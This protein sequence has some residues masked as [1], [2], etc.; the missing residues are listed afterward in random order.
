MW[1]TG[2]RT[3][4]C[5]ELLQLCIFRLVMY[6]CK[7]SCLANIFPVVVLTETWLS[8]VETNT[9]TVVNYCMEQGY[10][11]HHHPRSDGRRGGGAI[12][13]LVSNRIKLTT[14][15]VS[16]DPKVVSL[17]HPQLSPYGSTNHISPIRV[18]R[19][20]L[21]CMLYRYQCLQIVHDLLNLC[22]KLVRRIESIQ[23]IHNIYESK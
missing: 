13:L 9:A 12:G 8:N 23:I 18:C 6:D 11:L 15:Q 5:C 4:V 3:R 21:N 19:R 7:I 10:T 22:V 2:T 20:T 14:R 17:N 1:R 16:V